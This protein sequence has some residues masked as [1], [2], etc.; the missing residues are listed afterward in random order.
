MLNMSKRKLLQEHKR[1]RRRVNIFLR[2]FPDR[3]RRV[4]DVVRTPLGN[5]GFSYNVHK[6]PRTDQT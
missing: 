6:W 3:T 5:A 2:K 4:F 1:E